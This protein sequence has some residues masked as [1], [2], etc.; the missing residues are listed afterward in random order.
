MNISKKIIEEIKDEIKIGDTIDLIKAYD[1]KMHDYIIWNG[2]YGKVVK[3]LNDGTSI[4][5]AQSGT[6]FI[7]PD[8]VIRRT[9]LGGKTTC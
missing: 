5:R 7:I 9:R 3:V 1:E 2:R 6:D 4:V 8:F